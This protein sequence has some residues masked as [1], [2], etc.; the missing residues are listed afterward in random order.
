MIKQTAYAAA[1]AAAMFLLAGC[2]QGAPPAKD[3]QSAR[4]TLDLPANCKDHP[5]LI[6]MPE[7][8]PISAK[9]LTSMDCQPFSIEMVWG[10]AGA[11]TS[12]ILVDSQGP[13]GDLSVAMA[14]MARKLPFQ[15][16]QAAVSMT[17]GVQE[18]ALAYP[19]SLAELG[20]PDFLS[21]VRDG[22]G[23]LRYALQVEPKDSGGRV[24][25]LV[26]TAKE[27]YALTINIEH[28]NLVGLAA[29]EAAYAPWLATMRLSQLP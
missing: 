19:A 25:S 17:E 7:P 8:V 15:A 21:V 28:D 26:G 29:G 27:R 4:S 23:G 9:A 14:D 20:G 13:T 12:I 24:G 6:A 18:M 22:A 11:S 3:V 2:S 16:A 10:D 1:T 5:L